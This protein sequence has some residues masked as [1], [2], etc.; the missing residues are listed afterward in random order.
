MK[1]L[2]RVWLLATPWTSAYQNPPSKGFS[3]EEYWSGVTGNPNRS[4]TTFPRVPGHL[5][6]GDPLWAVYFLH[7]HQVMEMSMRAVHAK[8]L[9]LCPTLCD[10]I[11]C[12]PPGTVG[13]YKQEYWSGL[14]CPPPGNLSNPGIIP[15]SLMSPSWAGRFF[16]SMEMSRSTQMSRSLIGCLCFTALG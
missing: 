14:P 10:P 5:G 4:W 8:L 16:T 7:F 2:S 15:V 9:Q 1:S 12:S 6:L 13:F 11:S 3:R